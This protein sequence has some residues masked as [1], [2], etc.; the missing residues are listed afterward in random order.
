MTELR[1]IHLL[2]VAGRLAIALGWL[3]FEFEKTSGSVRKRVHGPPP[4]P[5]SQP[6]SA[7]IGGSIL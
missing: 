1:P 5:P 3:M 4:E 7:C 2:Q 6:P